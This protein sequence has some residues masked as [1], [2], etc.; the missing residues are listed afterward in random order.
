MTFYLFIILL[1][2]NNFKLKDETTP[3]TRGDSYRHPIFICL[4]KGDNPPTLR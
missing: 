4:N 3:D 2:H 1:I